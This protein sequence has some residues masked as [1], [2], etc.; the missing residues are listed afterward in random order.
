MRVI[1]QFPV[2]SDSFFQALLKE[3]AHICGELVGSEVALTEMLPGS[4]F[5]AEGASGLLGRSVFID[6]I[7]TADGRYHMRIDYRLDG[8]CVISDYFVR[9]VGS[10][11]E[12][13]VEQSA[14]VLDGMDAGVKRMAYE[15][16]CLRRMTD[17]LYSVW[18][19]LAD[20]KSTDNIVDPA[21]HLQTNLIKI[22]S[23]VAGRLTGGGWLSR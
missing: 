4:A 11:C 12:V 14:T 20:E 3:V 2:E 15:I 5:C 8:G 17:H 23:Q 13:T 19:H 18:S 6:S 1:R 7:D 10:R 9:S 21:K 16:A 22:V